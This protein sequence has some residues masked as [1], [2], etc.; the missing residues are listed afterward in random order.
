MSDRMNALTIPS[1]R[2]DLGGWLAAHLHEARYELLRLLRY[3][4]FAIPT[5]VFPLMFYALFGLLLGGPSTQRAAYLFASY[6]VF[7]IIGPALFGFGVGV[8][9]ERQNGWLELKRIAPMP[10]SAYFF[11]KIVMS[12]IFA[13]LVVC[14]LS[15]LAVGVGGVQISLAQWL[16]L[17][18]VWILGVLPFCA[19]GLL[20]ATL[21]KGQAAV[22]LVN[23]IYLPMSVLSGL[24]MPITVFPPVMQKLAVIWPA[25]HLNRLALAAVGQAESSH[26][27][28][29]VL[30]LLAMSA[31]F[32]VLAARRL[33]SA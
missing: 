12:M 1:D 6:G 11:A 25:Y 24:W 20:I 10:I 26:P 2:G 15:G 21:V 28:G 13:L 18:A 22:A 19:L 3:P 27:A 5:L 29:H 31:L 14:L 9:L 16:L 17:L 7:A 4:G 30:T 8:A 23:V 32:L 33:R